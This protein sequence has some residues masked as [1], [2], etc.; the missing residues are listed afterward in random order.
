M[1][2]LKNISIVH[3]L[4][5]SAIRRRLESFALEEFKSVLILADESREDNS[6]L[7]DSHAIATLLVIRDL[8]SQ[9]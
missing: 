8:Q 6:M 5:N 9:R 4:G 1:Q 2:D 3:H 7:S